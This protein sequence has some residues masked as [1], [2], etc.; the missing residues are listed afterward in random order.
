MEASRGFGWAELIESV[1]GDAVAVHLRRC[2]VGAGDEGGDNSAGWVALV[3][4]D[5]V[6]MFDEVEAEV[7]RWGCWLGRGDLFERW[8]ECCGAAA[9]DAPLDGHVA[10]PLG[11]VVQEAAG[12]CERVVVRE[13]LG[14]RR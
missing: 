4:L 2:C 11:A 1:G 8:E 3:G 6:S 7:D 9:G 12:E 10:H 5:V 13:S 14:D